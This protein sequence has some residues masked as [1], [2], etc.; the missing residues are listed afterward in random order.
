M[1]IAREN[2]GHAINALPYF[3][4]RYFN[5]GIFLPLDQH[6]YIL[7]WM[8][9]G[10]F[11]R[12]LTQKNW[13]NLRDADSGKVLWQGSDDFKGSKEDLKIGNVVIETKFYD[14]DLLVN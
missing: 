11:N 14:G 7:L 2:T 3:S 5:L 8:T 1:Q 9:N 13:M 10:E 12:I 6:F 4:A